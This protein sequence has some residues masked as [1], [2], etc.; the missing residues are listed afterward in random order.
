MGRREENDDE[1][2]LKRKKSSL[3]STLTSDNP[4]SPLVLREKEREILP[5][6]SFSLSLSPLTHILRFRLL[7]YVL[8]TW[9]KPTIDVQQEAHSTAKN[10]TLLN[11]EV[12]SSYSLSHP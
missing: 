6:L 12:D 10:R 3:A 4:F 5:S 1:R 7:V 11:V 9:K 8:T 2:R